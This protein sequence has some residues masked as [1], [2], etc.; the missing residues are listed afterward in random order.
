MDSTRIVVAGLVATLMASG[1][2]AQTPRRAPKPPPPPAPPVHVH[3]PDEPEGRGPQHV[4]KLTRIIRIG[5]GATLVIENMTGDI[6]I[7]AG[8]PGE[9][10]LEATKRARGASE[11]ARRQL[12]AMRIDIVESPRRVEIRSAPESARLRVAVDYAVVVPPYTLVEVKSLSGNLSVSGV[13]GEV[14]AETVRGSISVSGLQRAA[15]LKAVTGDV[16]VEASTLDGN[17][18]ASSVSGAVILTGLKARSVTA[19]TV[20][21]NVTI[22][23]GEF[24][25]V[26]AQSFNGNVQLS[27][28][29]VRGGRYR[30]QSHAGN[31]TLLVDGAVG[32]AL[33]ANTFSGRLDSELPLATAVREAAENGRRRSRSMRVVY[34]DGSAQVV[35]T[36]FSGNVVVVKK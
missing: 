12:D 33:Q 3:G 2:F 25:R 18:S 11:Q 9:L 30:V 7:T 22:A 32:F 35:I 6:D 36:S 14:R 1:A 31:V 13:R 17:L 24:E 23:D 34:G 27:G 10:R 20:S 16:R 29:F 19:D 15:W 21:G 4:E 8:K 26:S 28:P 5:D